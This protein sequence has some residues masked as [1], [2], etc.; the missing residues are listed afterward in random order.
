MNLGAIDGEALSLKDAFKREGASFIFPVALLITLL[1][2]GYTPTYAAVFG[3]L[4][5]IFF[6]RFTQR[7]M[8]FMD[9]LDALALGAKN[10]IMTAVLCARSA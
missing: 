2:S 1:A 3:I 7:P 5:V 10:M 8:G 6:S 9:V 4:A